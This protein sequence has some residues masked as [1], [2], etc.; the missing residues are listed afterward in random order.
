M[1]RRLLSTVAAVAIGVGAMIV[2]PSV[3]AA[4]T[5]VMGGDY[6][7]AKNVI[8]IPVDDPAT[9][10][11]AGALFKP[12]G[13]GPFPAVV[14]MPVCGGLGPAEERAVEKRVADHLLA[15]GFAVLIVDPYTVR[16]EY[17][18]VC[19]EANSAD[20]QTSK[21]IAIRGAYDALAAVKALGATPAIDPDRVFLHGYSQGGINALVAGDAALPPK[22]DVKVAGVVA[23]YPYC[24][25]TLDPAVPTLVFVCEKDTLT[26]ASLCQAVKDKPNLEVVVYR[27]PRTASRCR[28]AWNSEAD[29]SSTTKRRRSTPS[30]AP[31][32]SWRR[33]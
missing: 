29:A 21:Q 15:K 16:N 24:Y 31:T 8:A 4:Q 19:A 5:P 25:D 6:R 20:E 17:V 2:L 14:Y 12:A 18:G 7:G 3:S 11:I 30:G 1:K 32:R 13:A 10:A 23:Y 33:T 9:K 27:A 28:K 22:Y 26:P